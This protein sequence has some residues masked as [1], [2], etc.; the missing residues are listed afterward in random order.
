M[1]HGEGPNHDRKKKIHKLGASSS[2]EDKNHMYKDHI[3]VVEQ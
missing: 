2:K 3:K 1:G